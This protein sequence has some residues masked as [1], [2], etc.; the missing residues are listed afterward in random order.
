M[1][2]VCV[3]SQVIRE[4]RDLNQQGQGGRQE[5][6]SSSS[7]LSFHCVLGFSSALAALLSMASPAAIPSEATI[8]TGNDFFIVFS[9]F[10]L[11]DF[12]HCAKI[13]ERG[14]SCPQHRPRIPNAP[15][16]SSTLFDL[17]L[18]R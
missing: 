15:I 4:G 16:F 10:C 13:P 7:P 17:I 6:A 1:N 5:Q 9:F 14:H 18:L 2:M 11:T 12:T 3:P 8:L